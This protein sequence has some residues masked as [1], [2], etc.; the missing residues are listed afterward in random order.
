M[1]SLSVRGALAGLCAL[2]LVAGTATAAFAIDVKGE[3]LSAHNKYRAKHGVP[4]LAWSSALAGQAQAWADGCQFEHSSGDYGENL[5][6][7]T[8]G[9]YS[10]GALIK[11]WYD[12]SA[13]Y[14]YASGESKNGKA[15]GHFTQ[16]VWAGT[17]QVGCGMT[18]C[19]GNN[20]LVCQ[21]SPSGNYGGEYVANVPP[22]K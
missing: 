1:T 12:E 20:I 22:P 6:T 16:M 2:A 14:D 13:D 7:G 8:A 11:S 5:A 21:Y 18:E 10:V 3:A 15:V 4:A 17:T 9:G 19:S